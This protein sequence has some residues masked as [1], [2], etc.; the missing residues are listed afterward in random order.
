MKTTAWV[1]TVAAVMVV[2]TITPAAADLFCG[3]RPDLIRGPRLTIIGLTAD[4]RLVSFREC[5]PGRLREI[6][7]VSGLQAPDTKLVGIDFRVQDGLLYGVGNGG[8]IYTLD[9]HTAVAT[10]YC[11]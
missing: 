6:G 7:S 1:L 10:L 9:T 8:G 4:Q 11:G 2:L 3:N 5:N